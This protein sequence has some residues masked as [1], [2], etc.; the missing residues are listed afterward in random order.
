MKNF[1]NKFLT[2]GLAI[3]FFLSLCISMIPQKSEAQQRVPLPGVLDFC[4]SGQTTGFFTQTGI[5]ANGT[6]LY[7]CQGSY[8]FCSCA[9]GTTIP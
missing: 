2:T 5:A 8:Y 4:I 9:T 7:T 1:K 3:T 6:K